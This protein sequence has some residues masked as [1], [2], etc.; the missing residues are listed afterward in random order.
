MR[1]KH[2]VTP[3]P[4]APSA[5]V[6]RFA[7]LIPPEGEV[8]D[9]AAGAGR[10]SRLFLRQG[11]KVTA[12]D[13]DTSLLTPAPGFEI[14][15]A[16]LEN[17]APWPLEGRKFQ[18]IVVTNY[19]FR[20]LF[21]HLI[22]ALA[23]DGVL[24]YETFAHGNETYA[25]TSPRNPAHLLQPDEL[26]NIVHGKLSVIAF[27]QGVVTRSKGPAVIQRLCAAKTYGPHRV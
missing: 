3:G 24:I 12:V 14:V 13:R 2:I 26:L 19:L 25:L 20:P 15:K 23:E 4:D 18:A 7:P 1:C 10:H 8:L 17:G 6:E 22:D 16:D 27:E 11:N 21:A 9:L 5:W